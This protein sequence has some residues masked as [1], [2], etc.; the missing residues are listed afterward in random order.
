MTKNRIGSR[1]GRPK[2]GEELGER[3]PLG[4]RVTPETKRRLDVASFNTGRS[5]SQEAEIRL[6]RSFYIQDLLE[7]ALQMK[8]G[9][10]VAGLIMAIGMTIENTIMNCTV[11][12]AADPTAPIRFDNEKQVLD[13]NT[14]EEITKAI[15]TILEALR[16]QG[17]I[18]PHNT[19]R[20]T[21]EGYGWKSIGET[22]AR[23]IEDTLREKDHPAESPA[24]RTRSMLKDFGID[25][26]NRENDR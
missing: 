1:R 16:P 3:V 20:K 21:A 7:D 26:A 9:Q 19:A 10:R 5:L 23:A 12:G 2:K 18:D 11:L 17:V 8:Y 4:L 24:D 25:D 14:Y 6:E 15:P 22:A 13:P